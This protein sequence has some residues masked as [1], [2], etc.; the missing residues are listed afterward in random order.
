MD[1]NNEQSGTRMAY[2][3]KGNKHIE[4]LCSL[5]WERRETE[6]GKNYGDCGVMKDGNINGWQVCEGKYICKYSFETL[7]EFY[8]ESYVFLA[9]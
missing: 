2:K 5:E 6:R 8:E 3:C 7:R 1:G 4:R 9:F